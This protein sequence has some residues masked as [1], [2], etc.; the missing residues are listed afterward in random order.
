MTKETQSPQQHEILILGLLV[1][2]SI[3][4]KPLY[5]W[6]MMTLRFTFTYTYSCLIATLPNNSSSVKTA[7]DLDTGMS[8][9]NNVILD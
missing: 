5:F 3:L 2:H 1:R 4:M 7:L 9:L 6:A 8:L